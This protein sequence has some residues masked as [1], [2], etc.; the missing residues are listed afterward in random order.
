MTDK[1]NITLN[2]YDDVRDL[3]IILT[4]KILNNFSFSSSYPCDNFKGVIIPFDD[5]KN[6][7]NSNYSWALQDLITKVVSK[8]YDIKEENDYV[9]QA[10]KKSEYGE[11]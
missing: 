7:P 2:T 1:P 4:D 6:N 8:R 9:C 3:S 11:I 5:E 10:E